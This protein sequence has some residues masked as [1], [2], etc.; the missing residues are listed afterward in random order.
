MND[1]EDPEYDPNAENR[2]RPF[3]GMMQHQFRTVYT[4]GRELCVDESLV[5]FQGRLHFRQFVRT[6]RARFGIKLYEL[7]T[8]EGITQLI[9]WF[10][11]E[12]GCFTLTIHMQ[13]P[14]RFR[15]Y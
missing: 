7:N 1:N 5:L 8:S 6:K 10:T 4:P 13:M 12:K 2:D 14:Q 15:K 3:L 11:L 9:C